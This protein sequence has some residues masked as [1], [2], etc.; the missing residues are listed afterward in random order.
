ML[1]PSSNHPLVAVRIALSRLWIHHTFA[2]HQT[3]IFVGGS[4]VQG[5]VFGLALDGVG[6]GDA[7]GAGFGQGG[8]QLVQ[9]VLAQH[10]VIELRCSLAVEREPPHFADGLAGPGLTAIILGPRRAELHDGIALS[11]FVLEFAQVLAQGRTGLTGTVRKHHRV[12]F[13][14][15]DLFS[16]QFQGLVEAELGPTGGEAGHEDVQVG[17][18][19]LAVVLF[20]I[21]DFHAVFGQ[22]ADVPDIILVAVQ[23]LVEG[24]GLSKF[25]D[26]HLVMALAKFAPHGVEHHLGQGATSGIVLHLVVIQVDAFPSCVVVEVLGLAFLGRTTGWPPAGL[27]FDFQPSIHILGEET[28]SALGKMPHFVDFQHHVALLH[29]FLQFG[30]APGARQRPLFVGVRTLPGLIVQGSVELVFD[31]GPAQWEGQFIPCRPIGILHGPAQ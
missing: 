10:I 25:P 6:L 13:E 2:A 8:V 28:L 29:G 23:E 27:F 15:Q 1:V 14:V 4:G 16:Q 26:L 7:C 12:R 30:G 3:V 22:G 17:R 20:G 5:V 31:A 19:G 18:Q 24:L 21:V 9:E 11:E